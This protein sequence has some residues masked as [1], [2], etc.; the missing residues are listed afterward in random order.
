VVS[1]DPG[2]TSREIAGLLAKADLLQSSVLFRVVTKLVG[3]D[4]KLKAG[5]IQTQFGNG[6][7]RLLYGLCEMLVKS[8]CVRTESR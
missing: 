2:M 3:V 6:Y 8:S 1:I 4:N 5:Y 7:C